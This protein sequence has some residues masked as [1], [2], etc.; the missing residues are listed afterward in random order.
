MRFRI[1]RREVQ[2]LSLALILV[3]TTTTFGKALPVF[4]KVLQT[5]QQPHLLP[6][7]QYIP[8]RNFDTRHVALDIRFDWEQEEF[9]GVET[10]SFTR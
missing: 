10:L 8:D 6:P 5:A 1:F 2:V 4:D 3:L 7:T 9:S